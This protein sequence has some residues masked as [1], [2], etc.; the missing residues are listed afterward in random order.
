MGNISFSL[1]LGPVRPVWGSCA[2]KIS[3]EPNLDRS[4]RAEDSI[5]H[6]NNIDS[7]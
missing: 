2:L 6:K 1:T 7:D 4:K 3:K 5:R